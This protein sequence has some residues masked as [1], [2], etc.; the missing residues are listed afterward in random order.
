MIKYV[1]PVT[2]QS[3][4][5]LVAQVYTQIKTDFG[6]LVEPLTVHSPS[7]KLLAAVWCACR[8]TL[9]VG[10]VR[11]E[12]K[13]AIATTISRM[14]QCPYCVEGHAIMLNAASEHNVAK[15]VRHDRDGHIVDPKLRGLIEWALATRSPNAK[16]LLSPPFTRQEAPQIIGTALYIHYINRVVSVLLSET[17][18]PVNRR[19][20]KDV[21]IRLAS[22]K[23]FRA[24][25]RV[26]SPGAALIL[27]PD[28][29]LPADLSW[30]EGDL[31]VAGALARFAAVVE[32][33]GANT[34]PA[35][36][37]DCV[38]EHIKAWNGEDPGLSRAWVEP[39]LGQL[40]AASQAAGRL[41]LLTAL[42]PYQVD[43]G[44]VERFRAHY[45]GDNQLLSAIAWASFTAARRIGTWLIAPSS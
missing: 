16:I 2:S 21:S 3:A 30:S 37:R 24:V 38:R 18:L 14:N 27:L 43:D 29:A 32:G 33:A 36:V 34:L 12:I 44:I 9:L 45:P 22:W 11:R 26:K 40:N 10:S 7:P 41:T 31:A 28:A 8:E 13:E 15:A 35:E 25:R 19:W 4:G 42:A 5:G 23:F 17:A 6:A 1:H 20:L 39:A